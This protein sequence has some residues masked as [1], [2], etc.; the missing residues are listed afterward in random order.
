[1]AGADAAEEA[2]RARLADFAIKAL[3]N[4]TDSAAPDHL[5]FTAG[6][7]NLVD[8]AFL[9]LGLARSRKAIWE[10]LDQTIRERLI[11]SIART[12]RFKPGQNNWL[13]FSAMVEA[14]L[15]SVGAE[16]NAV[17]VETAFR[18]HEQWYHGDG[19]YG[20]G[21]EFHWDYYN[22]YV[23]QP[24]LLEVVDL[25]S[26]VTNQWAA[27]R[28]PILERAVR[29]AAVQERLIAPEGRYP[30]LGRS[31]TYRCGAFHHLAA[32]A[33]RRELPEGMA[34]AQVRG[35]LWAVISRTLGSPETFDP[36]GWLR[37]GLAGWQPSLAESYISTGSLYLC[38]TAFLPLGLSP[39][40]L[41]WSAPAAPWTSAMAWAGRDLGADHAIHS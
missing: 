28:V 3:T 10:K 9:A 40:D 30:L 4:A 15:A 1:V 5:D 38:T 23:I 35:A 37:V 19:A 25:M 17:P 6:A 24:F 8:A 26:P 36:D 39:T 13:L 29:F 34:A 27:L 21:P 7:Q 2:E 11:A 32:M 41:F 16:W 20:D 31:I 12:R 33:L 22:S 18:A 14:F